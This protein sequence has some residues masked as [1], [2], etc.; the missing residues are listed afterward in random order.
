MCLLLFLALLSSCMKDKPEALPENLVWNPEL[1]FPVGTDQYGMNAESGFDTTL[2]ELDTITDLPLW[3]DE[4]EVVLGGSV[5]FDLSTLDPRI[6]SV[7]QVLFRLGV[8][9]GFPN[10]ALAQAYFLNASGIIIDSMFSDGPISV[11]PGI[12]I[13]EGER[14][15]PAYVRKDAIFDQDRI[16]PLEQATEILLRTILLNHGIDTSLVPYYP[17]Y[18]IDVE[19]GM[20]T[21]LTIEL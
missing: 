4:V 7:N 12:P 20:M 5:E 10:D 21:D 1:A 2:F 11:P 3:V 6:D 17:F 9:N 16:T 14:I 15:D 18:Y 19:L 13:G 8:R